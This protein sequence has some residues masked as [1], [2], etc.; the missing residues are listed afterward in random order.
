MLDPV[1][2]WA[3]RVVVVTA[4]VVVT[5]VFGLIPVEDCGASLPDTEPVVMV[6]CVPP[7]LLLRASG[8]AKSSGIAV[9]DKPPSWTELG[10]AEAFPRKGASVAVGAGVGA[11]VGCGVGAGVGADVG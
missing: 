6:G 5:A 11:D 10:L 7:M 3:G 1:L 9:E 2:S 4:T 8:I